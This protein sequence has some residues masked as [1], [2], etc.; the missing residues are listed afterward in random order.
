MILEA[1]AIYK[2]VIEMVEKTNRSL[3]ITGKAGT[4]KTTMLRNIVSRK[5]KKTIVVAP[6]GV[7]AINAEGVTIHS[8]FQLPIRP[9][10]PTPEARRWLFSEQQVRSSRRELFRELELLIIDEISMVRADVL[11]A[12]D[13]VLRYY[14]RKPD[15]PFG[16]VQ[17]V[18]FGDLYQL[19]PVL[20]EAEWGMMSS[21]YRSLYFFDSQVVMEVHP[22]VVELDTIFRQSDV[23]FVG[24]LNE[25]RNNCVSESSL[26]MLRSRYK[27]AFQ[28]EENDDR[29]LLTTHNA[30]ADDVNLQELARLNSHSKRFTAVVE[31]EFPE[32]SYPTDYELELKV[33]AK[34]MFV[35]N[36]KQMPRRYYNG[37]IGNVVEV[38]EDKVYVE[39]ENYPEVIEVVRETWE[40]KSYKLNKSTNEI[41]ETL[42]GTFAQMP[43]RLAW[44]I[45]IHKSQ[46]LTF[47]KVV[48]DSADAFVSGQV[49]V[50]F[51]RCRSL[52]GIV[53]TSMITPSSLR[54]DGRVAAYCAT[55][56]TES[57]FKKLLEVDKI[58]YRKVLMLDLFDLKSLYALTLELK[59]LTLGHASSFTEGLA[60]FVQ[61][62]ADNASNIAAVA[63][64]FQ[65]QIKVLT[66]EQLQERIS[67]AVGYFVPLMDAE[68]NKIVSSDFI[69][70][71][72]DLAKKYVD[73]LHE[74]YDL[75]TKKA[76][77][78]N[79]MKTDC[80]VD[81]F[82][83][84]RGKFVPL[85]FNV[86]AYALER[87]DKTDD[88]KNP[89]LYK[90]LCGWRRAYCEDF[91]IP[92]FAMFSNQT[93]KDVAAYLPRTTKELERIK[94][95]GKV[96]MEKFGL[97]C[98]KIVEKYCTDHKISGDTLDDLFVDME[99]KGIKVDD[100]EGVA[101]HKKT[102]N[103]KEKVEKNVVS[104]YE[105]TLQ[106]LK[107]GKTAYEV[108]KDRGMKK[109]TILGHIA[110][111]VGK[112]EIDAQ[113]YVDGE[114]LEMAMEKFNANK[115]MTVGDLFDELGESVPYALLRIARAYY[116]FQNQNV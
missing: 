5:F 46:G 112:G 74:Y 77:I 39:C 53:L 26:E 66:D 64:R 55:A 100:N 7:A 75:L 6:T 107:E 76:Y 69:T 11:D 56:T 109:S 21:Y 93:L 115:D 102:S 106:M 92:L 57:D 89:M 63:S 90:M 10:L 13:A 96:K 103:Q 101:K 1:G 72:K 71:S 65:Q 44:A 34:V 45:T 52:E 16:G 19:P 47:D 23:K 38:D 51:S 111:L 2:S 18:M 86:K 41:E 17:V 84:V 22:V 40:N 3:F 30:K 60:D 105:Q 4:G 61:T 98:L 20:T 85:K 35:M 116:E 91:N 27:P 28:L 95:F 24:L 99:L 15:V 79:G 88:V 94:G 14:R 108:A 97:E 42:L 81:N 59:A 58:A 49:Y 31:K 50:A 9:L 8:F 70:E 48:I 73:A 113:D 37:M 32:K 68:I 43:L 67:A 114:I 25:L 104:T 87:L 110:V 54:V 82:F 33:G 83:D 36:D 78:M 29:I 80:S 12:I 62:L